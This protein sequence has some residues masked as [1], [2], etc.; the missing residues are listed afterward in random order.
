MCRITSVSYRKTASARLATVRVLFNQ[1]ES[2]RSFE[3]LLIEGHFAIELDGD[4]DQFGQRLAT[5]GS[6]RRDSSRR[7]LHLQRCASRG[8]S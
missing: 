8:C 5:D 7:I 4:A 1:K 3:A 6:N 2:R